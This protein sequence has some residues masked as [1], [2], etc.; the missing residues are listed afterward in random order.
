MGYSFINPSDFLIF[1]IQD[2]VKKE[3]EIL[4]DLESLSKGLDMKKT[5]FVI[6]PP[7]RDTRLDMLYDGN[8]VG[9][10]SVRKFI[11]KNAFCFGLFGHI[12]ESPTMSGSIKDTV[13][14]TLCIQPGN[15]KIVI[16]DLDDPENA[17][18]I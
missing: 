12:H 17:K 4:K 15:A 8:H 14:K 10:T 11:E 5:I 13:G 1:P 9:S 18:R 6:H 2:W 3:E 7:P 16:L